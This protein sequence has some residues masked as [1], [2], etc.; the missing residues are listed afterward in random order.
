LAARRLREPQS[1]AASGLSG[2]V[3]FPELAHFREM[4]CG[5]FAQEFC[6]GGIT[7]ELGDSEAELGLAKMMA[8]IVWLSL[9]GRD[10]IADF[11]DTESPLA[12]IHEFRRDNKI[13][14]NSAQQCPRSGSGYR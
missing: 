12:G 4:P 1:P 8:S 13:L 11:G 10:R 9:N 3:P 14:S 6:G 2:F 5:G 7:H